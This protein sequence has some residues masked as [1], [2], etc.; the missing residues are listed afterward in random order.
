[1]SGSSSRARPRSVS[2]SGRVPGAGPAQPGA[3]RVGAH[4][5]DHGGD[6]R[7]VTEALERLVQGGED[8][9]GRP[10]QRVARCRAAR[11]GPR[12]WW[13]RPPRRARRRPRSP[14]S[15]RRRQRERVVPVAADLRLDDGGPVAHRELQPGDRGG[16]V[17]RLRCRLVTSATASR[18]RA[19]SS[20]ASASSRSRRSWT[21]A[22]T[23]AS[24]PAAATPTSRSTCA[25]ARARCTGRPRHPAAARRPPRARR[26]PLPLVVCTS[27]SATSVDI[28]TM[29]SIVCVRVT[30]ISLIT[31]TI[32]A[33]AF[34]TFTC[35]ICVF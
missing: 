29:F 5:G 6:Q 7:V 4:G 16:S 34:I 27:V 26:R 28:A 21:V 31:V 11:P 23:R 19:A 20:E 9:G 22:A 33:F 8:G 30:F 24:T 10:V 32:S 13:R 2:S 25:S 35:I 17:S 15:C 18:A 12:P 3:G 14:A 1:M